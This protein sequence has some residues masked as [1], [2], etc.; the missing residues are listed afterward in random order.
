[1]PGVPGRAGLSDR[2]SCARLL[3]TPYGARALPLILMTLMPHGTSL[4]ALSIAFGLVDFATVAPT[5][6][7]ATRHF[8]TGSLGMIFGLLSMAHQV[9]SALGSY[10]PGA[11]H[12]LT[13]SH[14]SSLLGCAIALLAAVIDCLVLLPGQETTARHETTDVPQPRSLPADA[15]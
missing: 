13:G 3:A 1:M 12:N 7:I 5:H 4:V 9:G 2:Y 6:L 14:I 11:L 8:P 15:A 10:I